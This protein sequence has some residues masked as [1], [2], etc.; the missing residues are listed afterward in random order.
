MSAR[1]LAAADYAAVREAAGLIDRS[2][3]GALEVTGRD[4]AA[5]LH[6]MLSNDVAA[7]APGRGCA[8]SFLDV[9]G[10]VQVL[11][12]VLA[13]DDR[14]LV[15]TPPG[16]AAKTAEAL[17][18]Y[19]FS[20]KAAFRDATGERALLVLA[21]PRAPAIA[22]RLAGVAVP[23]GPWTHVAATLEGASVRLVQG[24][25][26]TGG[27][28]VWIID[29]AGAAGRVRDAAVAAGARPVTSAE[30]LEAL[31]IEAGTPRYGLDVDGTVLLPEI[32]LE[33]FVSYTKGCYIGQEVVVRIRDRGHVNRHLR[34]L[35]LEGEAVPPPS[36]VV[37]AGADE[38]GRVT[39]AAW[40]P[41]RARPV[42][43]A[44]VRRQHAGAG[45]TVTVR[46]DGSEA[47]ATVT[48]L[49]MPR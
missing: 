39:S 14:L 13:L 44:F 12:T 6:A 42:A 25:A 11:L 45:T 36:A 26:E 48:A 9:H 31:R 5:F 46:W 24:A 33:P 41:G 20:E 21:G 23:E 17:D 32:P 4:R 47:A 34:G 29:G 30:A 15:L 10:K 19:L 28:E 27:P 8:A 18:R 40:S 43:L 16:M 2:D 49:P 38:V 1:A 3:L 35:A 7:L 37:L 22:E